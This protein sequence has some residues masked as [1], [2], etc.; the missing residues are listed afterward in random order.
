MMEFWQIFF[1]SNFIPHG[2]CYLWQPGLV[3]LHL[4]SDLLIALAYYSI[5][6]MLVLFIRCRSDVPFGWMFLMFGMFIIACGTTHIMDVWTLWHPTYWVAGLIKAI[7]AFISVVTAL[8]LLTVLPKLLDLPSPR[9]L[10]ATNIALQNEVTE[11]KRTEEQLYKIR[12]ELEIRVQ[13][14][15]AELIT[16]NQSLS[17]EIAERRRIEE[18]LRESEEKFRATFNQAAVGLAHVATDGRWLLVNQR[19]CDIIGYTQEELRLLTFQD[20][21]YPE[22]LEKDIYQFDQMLAGHLQSCVMEKRY[23]HKNGSL[24]WVNITASFVRKS[25]KNLSYFIRVIEDI[26]ERKRAEAQ[27]QASLVEKEVLL[28]EIYHRVKNNLQV[29]SSLLN[30]QSEYI[31]D[32]Q[33]LE[34]FKHS[35][36]RI[37]S[38]AL[39][40][41]KLYQSKDLALIDFSEYI[42]DLVTSLFSYYEE[43]SNTLHFS[44]N[45]DNIF[46][47]LDAAIPCGL[48]INELVSNSLKYA[49]PNRENGEIGVEL[50]AGN[51]NKLILSV[52]DNGIGLPPEFDFKNTKTLGLQLV[53]ALTKQLSGDIKVKCNN[54]V[55]FR[56]TF[57][58]VFQN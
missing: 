14:R 8:E 26:S 27:I 43:K 5:P 56:I 15:T 47:G 57:P 29:I 3:S 9:Q 51:D 39:I 44:I 45:V 24:I 25:S 30:L 20:I 1:S 23:F 50:I 41:E 48:I 31:R 54:G 16:I 55:Y 42:R 21:T 34:M 40:H 58:A 52:C 46:L 6:V 35:Q 12:D 19:F 53:D 22:D 11:R 4:V 2:H 36:R 28:K 10:E 7:T 17:A 32:E 38:M 33:D 18:A 49:F 13:Q 37:E